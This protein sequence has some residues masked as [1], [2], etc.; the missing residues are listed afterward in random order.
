VTAPGGRLGGPALLAHPFGRAVIAVT[1]E[2]GYRLADV[3]AFASRAGVTEAEF[4]RHLASKPAAVLRVLEATIADFRIAVGAAYEAGGTWPDS[5]RA[6]G[7]EAARRFLEH[8]DRTRFALV[9]SA[10]AGDMARARREELYLWGAA[11]I[12]AG[13]AHAADPEAV[14]LRA[15]IVAVGAVVEEL[16]RGQETGNGEELLDAVPRMMYAVV[17]PYLG[18]AAARRELARPLPASLERLRRR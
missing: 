6:A 13:R 9:S 3:A 14:P 1:N 11:L 18:E 5:L 12:D 10:P 4:R 8:P 7:Y 15:G 2:R 17:R 16:R